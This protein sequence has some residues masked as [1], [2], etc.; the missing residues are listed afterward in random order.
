MTLTFLA[1]LTLG[2]PNFDTSIVQWFANLFIVAPALGFAYM[3][4]A[5]WSLVI[6]VSFMLG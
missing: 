6:E 1:I 3:D 5:Y 2:P 4:G